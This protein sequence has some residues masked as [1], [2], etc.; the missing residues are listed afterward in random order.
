MSKPEF[1]YVTELRDHDVVLGRGSGPNDRQGNINFRSLC[2]DKKIA[3]IEATSRDE[4]GR[5]AADIVATVHGRGGRFLK[6]LT[7]EQAKNVD[8]QL[9]GAD[10]V[11]E[12]ADKQTILE[13][14]KQTLR[15]NRADFVAKVE[16]E[17]GRAP[18][19]GAYPIHQRKSEDDKQ[20]KD[21]VIPLVK[22]NGGKTAD[23]NNIVNNID[24]IPL[25]ES[26]GLDSMNRPSMGTNS[27]TMLLAALMG[28]SDNNLLS[29]NNTPQ[30]QGCAL[31]E[32]TQS[33]ISA[34][35]IQGMS[36]LLY[37]ALDGQSIGTEMDSANMFQ[38]ILNECSVNEDMADQLVQE[39][40][41]DSK[42]EQ[43]TFSFTGQQKA[44][45]LH[46]ER[47]HQRVQEQQQQAQHPFR[48]YR[49]DDAPDSVFSSLV[50]HYNDDG[51]PNQ[52]HGVHE[53]FFANHSDPTIHRS[54]SEELI[55]PA[56]YM[57]ESMDIS[58]QAAKD[59][60]KA[61]GGSSLTKASNSRT[62]SS[63]SSRKSMLRR[64]GNSFDSSLRSLM[65]MS[66]SELT[67][68]PGPSFP[69]PTRERSS[70]TPDEVKVKNQ[71]DGWN[72]LRVSELYT[73]EDFQLA[74][75]TSPS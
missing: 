53:E 45:L 49:L 42:N 50:R 31:A 35:S 43:G 34:M 18:V 56:N 47:K 5:I 69:P 19:V 39:L 75:G 20:K 37:D 38:S 15:Q 61:F 59:L 41:K 36:M 48:Q 62:Y 8:V 23:D 6:R 9:R 28:S 54:A 12:L 68:L 51:E 22:S 26:C 33:C 72:S 27:A 73:E 70:G 44:L 7:A 2:K 40:V 29:N 1:Q 3:Y 55:E 24:P 10:A 4:K 17:V 32:S 16:K 46:Y 57:D 71:I 52:L 25:G 64:R 11:Y 66:I 63:S 30:A 67:P 58:Y 21:E 65:S 13:K 74:I 60:H 14:T